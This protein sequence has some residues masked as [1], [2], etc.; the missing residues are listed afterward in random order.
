MSGLTYFRWQTLPKRQASSADFGIP[1]APDDHLFAM[2]GNTGPGGTAATVKPAAGGD[3]HWEVE[4]RLCSF[5]E[6][7]S[8][9]Q[10]P[11]GRA[12]SFLLKGL[13]SVEWDI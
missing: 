7:V 5:L 4:L 12:R 10:L 1:W 6:T 9:A 8:A 2:G 11:S 13:G 3:H